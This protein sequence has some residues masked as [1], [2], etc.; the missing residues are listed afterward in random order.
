VDDHANDVV[1]RHVE[2]LLGIASVEELARSLIERASLTGGR[3]EAYEFGRDQHSSASAGAMLFGM[4]GVPALSSD[5]LSAFLRRVA[6]LVRVNGIV[7]GHDGDRIASTSSWAIAQVL[8]GLSTGAKRL[9][10]RIPRPHKMVAALIRLQDHETGGWPLRPGEVPRPAFSFYPVLALAHMWRSG[11]D[12]SDQLGRSLRGAHDYLVRCL[13]QSI[14]PL[15]ELLLAL[16]AL[17][18]LRRALAGAGFTDACLDLCA[19]A[20]SLRE[21]AWS[22][23]GGV[24]LRNRPVTTYRQPTWH[25][26]LWRPLL[27]MAVRGHDSPLSPLDAL[28][29]HELV[30]GF[31]K[32]VRAWRGPDDAGARNGASWASALALTG[33]FMLATDLVRHD[34]TVDQW[35]DHCRELESNAFEFDVAISFGGADRDVASEI[36][37]VLRKAGYRVFYDL[38][39]QHRLL[40][41]DLAEYLH[42]MYFRRS[43]YAI[44]V[45]S[46]HFLRSRWARN[47]EWRAMLARAQSQ[48]EPYVLPY[49]IE[50]VNLPGLNPTTGYA[51]LDRFAPAEFARL[52]VRKLRSGPDGGQEFDR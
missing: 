19:T 39:E 23:T 21:R 20:S 5:V 52:V 3:V 18:I 36:S 47:W 12:R 42:D 49:V 37:D 43:R 22:P 14:E 6:C 40:G 44:V 35:L 17:V 2:K 33:T 24:L 16:R 34:I 8:L 51:T 28:L 4:A 13:R 41:E 30:G 27:W 11:G 31:R 9:G 38:D 15:E 7:K 10:V 50:D 45:L 32:D 26:T 1:R 46:E 48:R 25:M 29:A